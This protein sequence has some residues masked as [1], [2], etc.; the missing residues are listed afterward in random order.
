MML[1]SVWT[2]CESDFGKVLQSISVDKSKSFPVKQQK[3]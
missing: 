1:V 3:N 2:A